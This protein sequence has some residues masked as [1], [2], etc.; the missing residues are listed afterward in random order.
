ML[1]IVEP[2]FKITIKTRNGSSEISP[3]NPIWVY[4]RSTQKPFYAI[5]HRIDVGIIIDLE[6]ALSGDPALSLA[7][8]VQSQKL[9]AR[10]ISR[11]QS[12]PACDIGVLCDTVVEDVQQL[13]GYDRVMV[14]NFHDDDHGEV[15]SETRRPDL[16]PYLGLHFPATDIPHAAWFLFK[17]N[18]VRMI[19][20]CL[21]NPVRIIQSKE[22][23][24]PLCLVNSTLRSR[25]SCHKKYMA[26]MGSIASLVLA[27]VIN[28][29]DSTKL[30]R[31]LACHHTSPRYITFA[32]RCAC[33]SLMQVFVLQLHMELQLTSQLAEKKVLQMQTLLC[34][35]LLRNA[36]CGIVTQSPSIMDLLKCDG[37][38]LYY[39][40][41]CWLQGVTPTES[42]IKHGESSQCWLPWCIF[43]GRCGLWHG[44]ATARITS[45]DFLFWFRSRTANKVKWAGAKHHP[46]DKDDGGRMHLRSSFI[47]FC[48]VVR[49]TSLPWEVLEINAIQSLQLIMKVY[50]RE[51]EDGD[52]TKMVI[53]TQ[54]NGSE[55][56]GMDEFSSVSCEMVR[57]IERASAPIFEVD[58]AGFTNAWSAKIA[59]LTGLQANEAMGNLCL[60]LFMRI[61]VE[62]EEEKSVELKLRKFGLNEQNSV[63]YIVGNAGVR[64]D[65][66]KKVMGVFFVGQDITSEKVVMDKFI[67]LQDDYK[68]IIQ[69]LNPLIP[70]IFGADEKAC[71]SEWNAALEKITGW[72][73]QEIISRMLPGEIFGGV[74]NKRTDE[75]FGNEKENEERVSKLKE[76]VFI[77]Q[78]MR[79]PL[80]GIRFIHKLL[81]SSAVWEDQKQLLE[82]SDACEKQM[83]S[84]VNNIDL[85]SIEE[86]NDSFWARPALCSDSRHVWR[87]KS[88]DYTG[89]TESK[90]VPENFST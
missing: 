47:V 63:L 78:E 39:G 77:R 56:K 58:L 18:R 31:L 86:E 4:S 84:I 55:E 28:D 88:M 26:N 64:R 15:V 22:L 32:L 7:E 62:S 19:C 79:N 23:K 35:I 76:L 12:V 51:I 68:A 42:Q 83:M 36:P 82:T 20:N 90:L 37:A 59:E 57:L 13:T 33:E 2:S 45:K 34:D 67:R 10:A 9:V 14:C 81:E 6:P 48:E 70:P 61:C 43:I 69:S 75:P 3:S 24:Q 89:M 80:N 66:T 72:T 8:A 11:L 87:R 65:C 53:Y 17:Q 41:K 50:F 49:N 5:L 71:C 25:H 29:K 52:D 85:G 54:H 46:E 16:E 1:A 38:A 21:A 74:S 30:W 73:R 27:I 44:M 40:G 60:M